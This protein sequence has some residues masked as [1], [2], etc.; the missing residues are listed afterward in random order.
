MCIR[1]RYSIRNLLV[2]IAALAMYLALLTRLPGLTIL[3]STFMPLFVISIYA[4]QAKRRIGNLALALLFLI[5]M[6]PAYA[7]L[8][9]PIS[10][11]SS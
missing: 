10:R 5:A 1:D 2:A 9:P 4:L 3:V 6:T 7:A 11:G 8:G